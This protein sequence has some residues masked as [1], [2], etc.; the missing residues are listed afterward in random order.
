MGRTQ[1][2]FLSKDINTNQ[3]RGRM[4]KYNYFLILYYKVIKTLDKIFKYLIPHTK[5]RKIFINLKK[6]F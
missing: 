6:Y 1:P 4:R 3:S 5:S 2:I